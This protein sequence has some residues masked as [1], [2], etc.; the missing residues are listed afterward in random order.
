MSCFVFVCFFCFSV[1]RLTHALCIATINQ[2]D[3]CHCVYITLLLAGQIQAII[4]MCYIELYMNKFY[5]NN[6]AKITMSS[7]SLLYTRTFFLNQ[8]KRVHFFHKKNVLFELNTKINGCKKTN[9]DPSPR[10]VTGYRN[11]TPR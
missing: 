2:T 7:T 6:Q 4:T 5:T 9:T 10:P 11:L 3:Q 8:K 1:P